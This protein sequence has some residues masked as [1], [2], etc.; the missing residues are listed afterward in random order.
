MGPSVLACVLLASTALAQTTHLVGP[1]GF[2][3]IRDALAI[4]APGDLVEVQN[5]TYAHFTVSAGVTIRAPQPGAVTIVYDPAYAPAGCGSVPVCVSAEGAT[6]F[7][8]PAGQTAHVVGLRLDGALAV[9]PP[10][11][12]PTVRQRVEV[13]GGRVTFDGCE[14]RSWAVQALQITAATVHL[15]D[16]VVEG[17]GSDVGSHGVRADSSVVT[18]VG[19]TFRGSI[20][21]IPGLGPG[22]PGG[23]AI[24]LTNCE[25]HGSGL[26]ARGGLGHGGFAN[27]AGVLAT[28]GSTWVSDSVVEGCVAVPSGQRHAARNTWMGAPCVMSTDAVLGVV[29]P[30]AI[31]IGTTFALDYHTDPNA[32]VAIFASPQLA[33][34]PGTPFTPAPHLD[35]SSL[36]SGGVVVANGTGLAAVS[37]AVPNVPAFV[38]RPLWFQGVAGFAFPL[39]TSPVAGG[40]IR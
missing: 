23:H 6:R 25:F 8:V 12:F 13:Q 40:V 19:G 34:N 22:W 11:P 16:C 27:G 3:Q 35:L 33:A 28:G 5:G 37:F 29:R 39:L 2:P 36:L 17:L 15:Q 32:S 26:D 20:R 24:L 4:A 9:L 10:N 18:V 30:A 21:G 14:F 31:R 7:T 38:G 1:G